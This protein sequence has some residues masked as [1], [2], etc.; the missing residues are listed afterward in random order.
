MNKTLRFVRNPT[1]PYPNSP[2]HI[3]VVL[4]NLEHIRLAYDQRFALAVV[5]ELRI[6]AHARG[7]SISAI[8]EDSFLLHLSIGFPV[9]PRLAQ[10]ELERWQL[11]LTDSPIEH[12]GVS[13]FPVVSVG[14]VR[15]DEL[16][17][18]SPSEINQLTPPTTTPLPGVQHTTVWRLSYDRDMSFAEHFYRELSRQHFA[19]AFQPIVSL[20]DPQH[21]LYEEG[22]LRFIGNSAQDET[23]MGFDA[24][25]TLERLGLI[26]RLDRS[27]VLN[28][29]DLLRQNPHL[30]LGCNISAQ[31]ATIDAW[32]NSIL[33]LLAMHPD[34]GP[35]LTLE[36]TESSSLSNVHATVEFVQ[37][38]QHLGCR[39]AI[40]DFGSG[41]ATLDFVR[42]A[43][44]DIIKVDP[45][46]LR[47]AHEGQSSS[48]TLTHLV[49]LCTTL[50]QQVIIEGIE[51]ERDLALARKIGVTWAQG[52][53]FSGPRI[54]PDW[55]K[56]PLPIRSSS[57]SGS[58]PY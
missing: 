3:F 40:D 2:T 53:L 1:K 31:S 10:Q 52:N 33:E 16:G 37:R 23:P 17:L 8:S 56:A 35:R 29:L 22:L 44:P 20:D 41:F 14:F 58:F 26:R 34:L 54:T 27:V 45:G 24:I 11:L 38:L 49:K 50:T 48:E 57:L 43:Q 12:E 7:A 51:N 13:V 30:K 19:L 5:R 6:R 36:I 9:E 21:T 32:W 46:F 55:S 25:G 39:M 28:V 15:L 4:R 18:P 47:R 42:R